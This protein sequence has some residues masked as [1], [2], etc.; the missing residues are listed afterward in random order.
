MHIIKNNKETI[1]LW[2]WGLV[3]VAVEFGT[4]FLSIF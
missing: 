2:L 1:V 3:L 4:N